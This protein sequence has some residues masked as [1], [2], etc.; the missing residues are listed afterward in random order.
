LVDR[1]QPEATQQEKESEV[2]RIRAASRRE[3]RGLG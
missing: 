1:Q 2:S 3:E